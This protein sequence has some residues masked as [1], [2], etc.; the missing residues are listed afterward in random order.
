MAK[1]KP[2]FSESLS[3]ALSLHIQF[4][5]VKNTRNQYTMIILISYSKN[6]EMRAQQNNH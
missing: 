6:S 2:R 5:Q 4:M 3:N 1:T